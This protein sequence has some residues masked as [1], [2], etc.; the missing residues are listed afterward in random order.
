MRPVLERAHDL[1]AER[2]AELPPGATC[3]MRAACAH[4]AL[5]QAFAAHLAGVAA[6]VDDP[7]TVAASLSASQRAAKSAA[8]HD[9]A[10][11]AHRREAIGT[12]AAQSVDLGS[13]LMSGS[14]GRRTIETSGDEQMDPVQ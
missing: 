9:A 2:L 13:L 14:P 5:Y 10:L 11:V 1:A 7:G 12:S 4:A 6:E 3:A 8:Q